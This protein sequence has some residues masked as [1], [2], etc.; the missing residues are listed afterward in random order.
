MQD[1]VLITLVG[2]LPSSSLK[3]SCNPFSVDEIELALVKLKLKFITSHYTQII[4]Y[5]S[6]SYKGNIN[7]IENF[8]VLQS[9]LIFRMHLRLR[10]MQ[11]FTNVSQY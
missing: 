1:F 4:S 5:S 3:F 8:V 9:S 2:P 7:H 11:L 6:N 10:C